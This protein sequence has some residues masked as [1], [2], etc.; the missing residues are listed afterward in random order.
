MNQLVDFISSSSIFLIPVIVGSMWS[1]NLITRFLRGNLVIFALY[2]V[3]LLLSSFVPFVFGLQTVLWMSMAAGILGMTVRGDVQIMWKKRT[4]LSLSNV[5]LGLGLLSLCWYS[6]FWLFKAL[7]PYPSTLNWDT[8]EHITLATQL[9]SGHVNVFPSQLTDT[10]TFNGYTPLFHMLLSMPRVLFG[11][12]LMGTYYYAEWWF[13]LIVVI[14]TIWSAQNIVGGKLSALIAGVFAIFGFASTVVYLPFFFL[15][16]TLAATGSITLLFSQ[17]TYSKKGIASLCVSAISLC[18]THF[19]I[20]SVGLSLVC[21]WS[22]YEYLIYTNNR[23]FTR[24]FGLIKYALIAILALSLLLHITG[25]FQL[26][27]RE[28]AQYYRFSLTQLAHFFTQWYGVLGVILLPISIFLGFRSPDKKV[29]GIVF[30][31]IPLFALSFSPLSYTLKFFVLGWFFLHLLFT[32]ALTR[33]TTLFGRFNRV[34]GVGIFLITMVLVYFANQY[35]YKLYLYDAG[36]ESH[37]SNAEMDAAAFLKKQGAHTFIVSDPATQ[38]VLEALGESNSQGGVYMD[39]HARELLSSLKT[40]PAARIP[41]RVGEITDLL[42]AEAT[43]VSK[44]YFIA[45]GR[46]FQ[47]QL[48]SPAQKASVFFNI[49]KPYTLSMEDLTKIAS[50]KAAGMKEVYHSSEM[51]IFEL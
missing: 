18:I 17:K 9:I 26:T 50:F 29:Q 3:A 38:G 10:F 2:F 5:V 15:P 12:S 24:Y 8:F 37:F 4:Q 34:L 20:A 19:V 44:R 25:G 1:G 7:T 16:Q 35:Q 46:Y 45:S 39:V 33:I 30:L 36:K 42:P 23:Y 6:F 43:H 21:A 40:L 48:F 27:G 13:F 47:W 49:W 31:S 22:I 14:V 41:T 11:A 51:S 32:L 28:E